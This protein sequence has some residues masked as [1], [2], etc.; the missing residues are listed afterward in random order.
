[1]G[2][3]ERV[4][5][6]LGWFKSGGLGTRD[7]KRIVASIRNASLGAGMNVAGAGVNLAVNL[8]AAEGSAA[9]G[10]A[11]TGEISG[12]VSARYRWTSDGQ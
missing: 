4:L 6:L 7:S 1:M 3:G 12:I 9:E 11:L 5:V 2:E 10:S 8:A